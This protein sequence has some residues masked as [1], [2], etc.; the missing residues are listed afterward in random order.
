[1]G[2]QATHELVRFGNPKYATNVELVCINGGGSILE[3]SDISPL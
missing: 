1:M 2:V 3:L